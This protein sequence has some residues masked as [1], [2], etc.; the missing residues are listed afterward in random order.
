MSDVEDLTGL[1]PRQRI[2]DLVLRGVLGAAEPIRES[3][4]QPASLDLRLGRRAFR[5]RASFLPGGE[6]SVEDKLRTLGWE[7]ID[8]EKGAIFE[9]GCVYVV[10]LME[11]LDLPA[12]ISAAANPKSSTGRLDVFTRLIADRSEVF[13]AVGAGYRGRL[14]AEVSPRTFSVKVRKGTRLNQL[15]FRR[16]GPDSEHDGLRLSDAGLRELHARSP[17]VDGAIS[18]R[19]GLALRIEL[20][21][22]GPSRLVGYRAQRH[23]DVIDLDRIGHYRIEDYWEPVPAR[24]DRRLILDPNEFYI[25]VSKER[26]HIPPSLAAEMVPIDPLMGEFRV[27]YAG[28]FDPG[29]GYAPGGHP[30]S[31]A[32]MEVRSHE[33]PF[34]LED[35]QMVC[36]LAYERM[37]EEP[38][39]LYGAIGTSNYQG[40]DLKLSKQFRAHP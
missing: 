10:E 26:L 20:S 15:R 17:L 7:E 21:G 32:V 38:D 24:D 40:Q 19:N 29:F 1:M 18:I 5:V 37:A 13:D 9:R 22:L 2:R 23:T 8:L 25:L 27:H 31:R 4:Y 11:R 6:A 12:S 34:N 35:G 33:V 39:A 3:Q 14:Y 28:F 16:R 30:G 36:R